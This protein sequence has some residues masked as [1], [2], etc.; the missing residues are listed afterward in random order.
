MERHSVLKDRKKDIVEI[1]TLPKVIYRFNAIIIKIPIPFFIQIEKTILKLIRNY[2]RPQIA[3][4]IL[5]K[6]K[7]GGSTIPDFKVRYK[8]I[9]IKTVW[10][11]H[12]KT[13]RLI[14]HDR[15]PEIN[16][17]IHSQFIYSNEA[18]NI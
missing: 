6:K 7:A 12:K 16:P 8:A 5:R 11:W 15:N 18:K 3:K 10:Y 14:E 2:K 17:C 13:H 4:A 1:S 9:V